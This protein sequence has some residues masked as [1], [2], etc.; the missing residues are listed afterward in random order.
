MQETPAARPP[1]IPMNSYSVCSPSTL[2]PTYAALPAHTPTASATAVATA[3]GQHSSPPTTPGGGL[4]TQSSPP[5]PPPPT[6]TQIHT[7][8][9]IV[10]Q[11]GGHFAGPQPTQQQAQPTYP[12]GNNADALSSPTCNPASSQD[13]PPPPHPQ[14]GKTGDD[15]MIIMQD[16]MGQENV[17]G[18]GVAMKS[19][20]PTPYWAQLEGAHH[21]VQVGSPYIPVTSPSAASDHQP[22]YSPVTP[23]QS[24]QDCKF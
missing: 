22:C 2:P 5:P 4:P 19:I 1:L 3:G 8:T 11:G 7:P 9:T 16:L 24:P 10:T 15:L 21:V 14:Q 6:S 12:A 23:V 13:P 18:G 17:G 20:E